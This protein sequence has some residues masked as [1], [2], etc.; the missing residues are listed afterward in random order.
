MKYGPTNV[1]GGFEP[2]TKLPLMFLKA[3]RQ[4]KCEVNVTF[5]AVKN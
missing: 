2:R 3:T 5:L 4:H 1:F